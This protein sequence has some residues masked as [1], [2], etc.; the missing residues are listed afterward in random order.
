M[1]TR[2]A[3]SRRSQAGVSLIVV[4]LILL[5]VTVVGIG[6]AQ[7]AL[8]GERSTRYD[9][10]YLIASQYAE[11]ALIDAQMDIGTSTSSSMRSAS[12]TPGAGVVGCGNDSASATS[13]LGICQP[14]PDTDKPVWATVDFLDTS[15]TAHTVAFGTFTSRS[16]QYNA[17][18]A[19]ELPPRYIIEPIDD[20]APGNDA[21]SNG[22][23][24]QKIY[25]ITAIGFG[26]RKEVQVVMQISYRKDK[27]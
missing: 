27:S 18:N 5:V 10:D 7:I 19:P 20:P 22:S 12:F 17:G 24:K 8:N 26:P 13:R 11:A 21:S 2:H 3:F 15:S 16:L 23:A 4:M 6:G 25:R 14:P 9:R 1:S